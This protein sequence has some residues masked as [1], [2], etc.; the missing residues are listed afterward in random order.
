[1]PINN[2][3]PIISY[4]GNGVSNTFAFPFKIFK[5]ADLV[6]TIDGV[7]KV[8]GADYALT[9]VGS[10]TGGNLVATIPP[11][12]LAKVAIYRQCSYDRLV[13]DYQ[14]GGDFLADTIDDDIDRVVAQV[15]QIARDL[16][17]AI[18]LPIDVTADQT[19]VSTA[20]QRIGKIAGFDS[21][22]NAALFDPSILSAAAVSAFMA[23]VIVA[24]NI[25]AAQA[26]LGVYSTAQV[27]AAF[28]AKAF[29]AAKGDL[30]GATANDVPAIVSVGTDGL[31]LTA[32]STLG[33]GIGYAIRNLERSQCPISGALDANG[34]ANFLTTG[35][36]LRPGLEANP[37]PLLLG[38][39]NG[40]DAGGNKDL[41]AL[42]AADVG[43]I[44]GADLPINQTSFIRADYTNPGA[45]VWGQTL[46]PQQMSDLFD[47]SK[48]SLLR[49]A[50][51]D[52]SV[53]ILD[54]YGNTWAAVGNAQVDTAV[55]I[56]ALNTLLCDG[57]GDYVECLGFQS[58]GGGSWTYEFKVRFNV[59][60][61]AG[62]FHT[63]VHFMPLAS[64][65]GTAIS[66]NNA[67]GVLKLAFHASS[68]GTAFDI[69]NGTLGT[70]TVW[71]TGTTYHIAVTY[72]AL[73]GKYL[74]M[75]DGLQDYTQAS[76]LRVGATP[77]CRIGSGAILGVQ[78]LNGA[79]AGFR[80]AQYCRYPNGTGFA[81]PSIATF[82]V[83]GTWYSKG[84]RKMYEATAASVVAGVNPTFTQRQRVF[85]GEAD[86]SGAAVT[87]VRSY[88]YKGRYVSPD[89]TIP[90]AG[91]RTAFAANLGA[92]PSIEPAVFSRNYTSEAGF[93]P[94]MVVRM[95][96]VPNINYAT[97]ELVNIE[98]RN[99]LSVATG[100]SG[101]IQINNRTTGVAVTG[102]GTNWKMFVVADRG[103]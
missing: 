11:A 17:R 72:D 50:G 103:F 60:P 31:Q 58:L 21:S 24:A 100:G 61:T 47:R 52:A 37:V 81:T 40:L 63:I 19:I 99:T 12:N 90:G 75:K 39:G 5:V 88:A 73:S 49:F 22:G 97:N 94:G 76:A 45:V 102:T 70:S 44:L 27:D 8:F 25:A 65:F 56:D 48:Q 62:N 15:Q 51:A 92:L 38:F 3:A 101:S 6:L 33:N 91:T 57:A 80:M 89:T 30:I 2:T 66:L 79:V 78:D 96:T 35:A 59:L 74:V 54:D 23:T 84:E 53:S 28:I 85:V 68:N 20:A 69:A 55:Q 83:E 10:I 46:V 95:M 64:A 77:R 1:M 9:G 71:A 82:A 13:P 86:T 34:A 93:T 16:G 98:D 18:K 32:D 67:A 42:L 26:A 41:L 36:G 4:L 14:E 43:D 7:L 87:A 29:M